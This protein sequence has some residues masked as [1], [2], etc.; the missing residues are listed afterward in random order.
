MGRA[1]GFDGPTGQ[2]QAQDDAQDHLLLFGQAVHRGM[3]IKT[4]EISMLI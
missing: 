1:V 3:L 4:L 2:E